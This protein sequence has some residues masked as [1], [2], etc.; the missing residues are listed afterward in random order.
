MACSDSLLKCLIWDGRRQPLVFYVMLPI[1][2]MMWE[3]G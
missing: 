2:D 3:M 1:L